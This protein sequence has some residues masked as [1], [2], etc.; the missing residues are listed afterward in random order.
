MSEEP[1]LEKGCLEP[2]TMEALWTV[3]IHHQ[4]LFIFIKAHWGEP[5]MGDSIVRFCRTHGEAKRQREKS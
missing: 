1:C 3:D 5:S 2:T 4:D